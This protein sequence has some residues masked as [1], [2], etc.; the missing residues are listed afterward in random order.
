MESC[1]GALGGGGGRFLDTAGH[2]DG[3]FVSIVIAPRS[4]ATIPLHPFRRVWGR[5]RLSDC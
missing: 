4:Q 5:R 1:C 3:T 2:V